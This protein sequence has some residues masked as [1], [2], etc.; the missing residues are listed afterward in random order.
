MFGSRVGF[1]A[2]ALAE[3]KCSIFYPTFSIRLITVVHDTVLPE[4]FLKTDNKQESCA[5][6]KLIAQY[7]GL[8]PIYGYPEKMGQSLAIHTLSIPPPKILYAYHTDYLSMCTRFPAILDCIFEW[9]LRTPILGKGR[10]YGGRGW[11]CW[12]ERW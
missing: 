7:A 9:R 6:A 10:P 11:Y 1:S 4:I 5:I 2:L 12:K 3:G 8:R